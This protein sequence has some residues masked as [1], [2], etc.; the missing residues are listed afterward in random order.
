MYRP[1]CMVSE[2]KL[3]THTFVIKYINTIKF[4]IYWSGQ[5]GVRIETHNFVNG[6]NSVA[7]GVKQQLLVGV[8][9]WWHQFFL[10]CVLAF[11]FVRF[12]FS[13]CCC[14]IGRPR[15]PWQQGN[16]GRGRKIKQSKL[17]STERPS[18]DPTHKMYWVQ[19]HNHT[20]DSQS[21]LI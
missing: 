12:G 2:L 13:G 19:T 10:L 1:D 17:N 7:V 5:H 6:T 20:S 9:R 14:W 11:R 8:T 18:I 15:S 3:C 4:T 16:S 21:N